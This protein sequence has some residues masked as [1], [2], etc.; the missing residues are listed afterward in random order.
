MLL[1]AVDPVSLTYGGGEM[2]ACVSE[3]DLEQAKAKLAELAT[4]ANARKIRTETLVVEGLPADE[5]LKAADENEADLVLINV[6]RKGIVQ[7]ALLGTTA[8][9]V[10]REAN[11]PVLSIPSVVDADT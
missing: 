2:V 11:V 9:R 6:A 4:E 8:E 1:H 3:F 10:I 7:R 5:I